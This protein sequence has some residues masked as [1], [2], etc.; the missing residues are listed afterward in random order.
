MTHL[1]DFVWM[2]HTETGKVEQV[3]AKTNEIISRMTSGWTQ[4]DAPAA[5]VAAPE[6]K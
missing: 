2:R 6:V 4:C 3:S 1:K 5:P